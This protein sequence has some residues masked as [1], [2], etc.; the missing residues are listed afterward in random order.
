MII[1]VDEVG[2][3]PL[4]GPV[5][6][7]AVIFGPQTKIAGLMD[8]KKLSSKKRENISKVI[9]S[10]AQAVSVAHASVDEID[11][12]NILQA[13]LLAMRRAV[14]GVILDISNNISNNIKEVLVDGSFVFPCDYPIRAIIKGDSKIAE[15][16][17]ASIVAKVYRDKLMCDLGA[18][19]PKYGFE[20]H[21]GY[22]TKA[23][24]E[25]LG[26]HGVLPDIYRQSFAPVKKILCL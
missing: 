23:H 18:R 9:W 2:R 3:G 26:Q 19:Y 21:M 10:E 22:P 11:G 5:V 17:A 16:S 20:R 15:I 13:S 8:S 4:A 12:L 7:A 24:L 6:A 14:E 1:G 25:A